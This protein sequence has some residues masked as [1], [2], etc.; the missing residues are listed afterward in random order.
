[1]EQFDRIWSGNHCPPCQRKKYCA[2]YQDLIAE[3]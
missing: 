2:D 1:M 3:K